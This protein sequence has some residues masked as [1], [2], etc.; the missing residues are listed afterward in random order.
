MRIFLPFVALLGQPSTPA[1]VATETPVAVAS[2]TATPYATATALVATA[3]PTYDFSTPTRRPPTA[4]PTRQP[5]RHEWSQTIEDHGQRFAWALVSSDV[6]ARSIAL[7]GPG[8]SGAPGK[9]GVGIAPGGPTCLMIAIPDGLSTGDISF[10]GHGAADTSAL[11]IETLS[12]ARNMLPGGAWEAVWGGHV[13]GR[14]VLREGEMATVILSF[15]NTRGQ[16]VGCWK[17]DVARGL[18][19]AIVVDSHGFD[20]SFLDKA[21]G[22]IAVFGQSERKR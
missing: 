15:R 16:L 14:E 13:G 9:G 6:G 8:L 4:T 3:S 19:A 18:P 11:S 17:G 1:T 2:Q 21:T 12:L 10:V 7:I 20:G 5:L 22:E